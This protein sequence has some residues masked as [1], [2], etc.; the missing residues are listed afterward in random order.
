[1]APMT[2]TRVPLSW[3]VAIVLTLVSAGLFFF[4]YL[5]N[6]SEYTDSMAAVDIPILTEKRWNV[7]LEVPSEPKLKMEITP[8]LISETSVAEPSNESEDVPE[9]EE[10]PLINELKK[11]TIDD[12]LEFSP[13][14][15]KQKKQLSIKNTS[16]RYEA[17][18]EKTKTGL[19]LPRKAQN[20]LR[21]FD[22][23][24]SNIMPTHDSTYLT[25]VISELGLEASLVDQILED[26][27]KTISCAFLPLGELIQNQH[28]SLRQKDYETLLMIPMEPMDYPLSDPG[29][30]TL[31]TNQRAMSNQINLHQIL[32]SLTG[33]M[34]VMPYMGSRF[35]RV[36]GDFI[37]ILKEIDERGLAYFEPRFM[38]S[39][40]SK[41]KPNNL[42]YLKGEFDI[43]RGQSVKNIKAILKTIGY[44]LGKKKNAVV[45]TVQADAVSLRVIKKW[46][47]TELPKSVI[48]VPLSVQIMEQKCVHY[49][50][51]L[52][53][54]TKPSKKEKSHGAD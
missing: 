8:L 12:A 36:K 33:Y 40:T 11:K 27:P 23:Y 2:L 10:I 7:P 4:F 44:V 45:L 21:P 1:M 46:M 32:S 13:E 19:L 48:L 34:G 35:G 47:E 41:W 22:V 9:K 31:L 42:P 26:F 3:V 15:D 28:D 14:A 43:L 52:Y 18:L 38:R 50:E 49:E 39:E 17:C 6:E 29:P 20:G 16:T 51:E 30:H 24:Q 5:E 37:P 54:D 25:I 53:G